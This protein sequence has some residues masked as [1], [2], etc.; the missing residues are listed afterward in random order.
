[1]TAKLT[2]TDDLY[3]RLNLFKEKVVDRLLGEESPEFDVFVE[4]IIDEGLDE[5]LRRVIGSDPAV[6]SK[7]MTLLSHR[8]PHEFYE[9]MEEI[10]ELG[11]EAD[12]ERA[13]RQIGF[14]ASLGK[15]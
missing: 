11:E 2:V 9:Y 3:L 4:G 8:S 1:M 5:T 7:S 13:R 12:K 14:L 10:L 15:E 6:L